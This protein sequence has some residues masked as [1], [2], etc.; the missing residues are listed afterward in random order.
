MI[1]DWWII[2]VEHSLINKKIQQDKNL[3][4]KMDFV[5]FLK[6]QSCDEWE[7]LHFL[8][9]FTSGYK[10][11]FYL[12]NFD[13]LFSSSLIFFSIDEFLRLADT[14]NWKRNVCVY[15]TW[16]KCKHQQL[17]L[18]EDKNKRK[19]DRYFWLEIDD[20]LICFHRSNW[21]WIKK[22]FNVK[23]LFSNW[24]LRRNPSTI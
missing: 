19:N 9:P 7:L 3:L 4:W 14:D 13:S 11:T 18:C 15:K 8:L 5:K 21:M 2:F 10:W 24:S 23:I 16:W 22:F 12:S 1:C 6:D 20:D 17:E